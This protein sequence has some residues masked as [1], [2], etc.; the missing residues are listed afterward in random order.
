MKGYLLAAIAL[1]S[2]GDALITLVLPSVIAFPGIRGGGNC[3]IRFVFRQ[4]INSC[5]PYDQF[6]PYAIIL[7]LL[8]GLLLVAHW[9]T[10]NEHIRN[11]ETHRQGI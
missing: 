7:S 5:N 8:G 4:T 11:D 10:R 2:V 3:A 6:L 9:A 1:L